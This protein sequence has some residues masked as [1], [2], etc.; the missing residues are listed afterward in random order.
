M[1][2]NH[3]HNAGFKMH[4]RGALGEGRSENFFERHSEILILYKLAVC[5]CRWE[6]DS[7]SGDPVVCDGLAFVVWGFRSVFGLHRAVWLLRG[8]PF[9]GRLGVVRCASYDP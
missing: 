1:P 3:W 2:A 7:C 6:L 8:I 5:T 9:P 4:I